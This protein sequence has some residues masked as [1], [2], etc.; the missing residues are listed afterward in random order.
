MYLS[1]SIYIYI[2]RERD[3]ER[4]IYLN[5]AIA[6]VNEPESAPGKEAE[7]VRDMK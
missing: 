7:Q 4:E 1:L 5:T 2:E 3:I 6:V